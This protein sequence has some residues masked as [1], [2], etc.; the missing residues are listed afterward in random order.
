[1][2]DIE[3]T[4]FPIL[5]SF[6]KEECPEELMVLEIYGT[7]LGELAKLSRRPQ[8]KL[9]D[10]MGFGEIVGMMSDVVTFILLI[11][12]QKILED[13]CEATKTNIREYLKKHEARIRE[14]VNQGRPVPNLDKIIDKLYQSLSRD[15]K[16]VH[17]EEKNS[18]NNGDKQK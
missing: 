1:M 17:Q 11:I 10:A 16:Q 5:E 9:D 2:N 3:T 8:N 6:I 7:K 18:A 12:A 13:S 14:L 15:N 4:V